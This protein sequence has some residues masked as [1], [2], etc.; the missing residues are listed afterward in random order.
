M[1]KVAAGCTFHADKADATAA[2]SAA[3][4]LLSLAMPTAPHVIA[5]RYKEAP[6]EVTAVDLEL[7]QF[8]LRRIG[9]QTVR[10][11]FSTRSCGS[12]RTLLKLLSIKK[13]SCLSAKAASALVNALQAL[14]DVGLPT[15]NVAHYNDLTGVALQINAALPHGKRNA[16]EVMAEKFA[17]VV[18]RISDKVE[19]QLY[20]KMQLE[21]ASGNLE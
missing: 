2:P 9:N 15:A 20:V 6:E 18:N 10:D 19:T 14:M 16:N 13:D 12:G 8:V 11:S 4:A 1:A 17:S 21:K 7:Q 5:R 3:G